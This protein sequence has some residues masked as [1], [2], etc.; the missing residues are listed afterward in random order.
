MVTFFTAPDSQKAWVS[1]L[2]SNQNLNPSS[3]SLLEESAS[4]IPIS[5]ILENLKKGNYF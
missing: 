1:I 4:S 3:E 5:V 2:P